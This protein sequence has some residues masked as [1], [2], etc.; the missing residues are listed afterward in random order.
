MPISKGDKNI[1]GVYSGATVIAYV[2]RGASLVWQAIR[3]CF[4]NG[5]WINSKAW[6]NDNGWKN[7]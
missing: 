3:S 1:A 6:I 7:N 4:G 5:F 2:Y